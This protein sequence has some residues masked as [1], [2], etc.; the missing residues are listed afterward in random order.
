MER[1]V[2]FST[3]MVRAILDG[4]K[5]QT[6]RVKK[7][8]EINREPNDYLY[9]DFLPTKNVHVF[10]RIFRGG[11]VETKHIKCP[12]GMI[13]DVLWV[14][15]TWL[16]TMVRDEEGFF[17]VYRADGDDYKGEWKPSIFMPKDACRIRLEINNIMVERLQNISENDAIAEGVEMV[18]DYGTTGYKLYTQPN[19]AYSDIDAVWS[20]ESLWESINGKNSWDFNPWVWVIKFK[21]I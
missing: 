19:S 2:L 15:E 20:Y 9:K 11:W 1:P 17:Y 14:R 3:P 6:R 21:R 7:L 5:T 12:Y 10:A 18:A 13:G 16:K 8:E 4:R